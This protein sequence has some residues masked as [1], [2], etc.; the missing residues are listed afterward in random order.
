MM[1]A[2]RL[3]LI[4]GLQFIVFVVA[5]GAPH[6]LTAEVVGESHQ[7][8]IF[9]CLGLGAFSV[10]LASW[11]V[12]RSIV[13]PL[14]RFT[15]NC[16]RAVHALGS[17]S[18][19]VGDSGE[20]LAAQSSALMRSAQEGGLFLGRIRQVISKVAQQGKESL[21]L[22]EES[23]LQ[24]EEGG[25]IIG[26]MVEAMS[27]L[28]SSNEQLETMLE[29]IGLIAKR[30]TVLND[31]VI[32]TQL[33]AF[34]ASVEASRA[35]EAG[36]GFGVVAKE[37][38]NLA[39]MSGE[40]SKEIENLLA[41]S[42]KRVKAIVDDTNARVTEGA[43]VSL[44]ALNSINSVQEKVRHIASQIDWMHS[45]GDEKKK[46]AVQTSKA[47]HEFDSVSMSLNHISMRMCSG[48]ALL[49]KRSKDL[50]GTL[51]ELNSYLFGAQ[52]GVEGLSAGESEGETPKQNDDDNAHAVSDSEVLSAG[53]RV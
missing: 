1:L 6:V 53:P 33:L 40:A 35:G 36:K 31:I 13:Q 18:Q 22:A 14:G 44:D 52:R 50:E 23:N 45:F 11:F 20:Q 10:F 39:S 24:A 17:T 48:A 26:R 51:V 8:V 28:K 32:K 19:E 3:R 47:I 37:V 9:V 2:T 43:Q 29:I 4:F 30:T 25:K 16:L 12:S 41:D 49:D 38:A 34:N 21:D 5:L 27:A 15:Q 42:R 7:A 46:A